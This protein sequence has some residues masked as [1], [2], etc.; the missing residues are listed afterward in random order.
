MRTLFSQ[1]DRQALLERLVRITPESRAEWGTMN[2][3][4]MLA[5]IG[6]Q[7]RV[8]L[9]DID[10]RPRPGPM[11]WPILRHLIIYVMPWPKGKAKAPREAFTTSPTTWDRDVEQF[12]A[13][14]ERF[15]QRGVAADWS[16]HPLFGP[17]SGRDWGVL[18]H[19]HLD[20]H[21]RQ[22]GG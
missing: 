20:H 1:S 5:H 15:V 6:D 12:R 16:P 17:L 4:K 7:L 21:L 19:R 11:N 13:L 9:G 2:A 8:A 22:F 18:T 3:P 10:T 14:V